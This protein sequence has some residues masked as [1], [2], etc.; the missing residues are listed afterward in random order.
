MA[1]GFGLPL[2]QR[3]KHKLGNKKLFKWA[4][5]VQ[6]FVFQPKYTLF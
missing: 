3:V 6:D 5:A 4:K 1:K 2:G